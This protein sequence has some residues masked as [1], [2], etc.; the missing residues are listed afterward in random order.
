MKI[1]DFRKKSD[2]DL[3]KLL[4]DKRDEVRSMRFK[5]VAQEVKNHQ[6]LKLYRRDIAKVLTILR[7]RNNER[8]QE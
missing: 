2:K 7:E 5:V 3:Q 6:L 4:K 1:A 8:G